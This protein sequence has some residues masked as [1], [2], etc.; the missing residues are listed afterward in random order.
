MPENPRP[1]SSGEI[2]LTLTIHKN[3]HGAPGGIVKVRF[4]PALQWFCAVDR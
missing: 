3:R 1:T 4:N 2:E